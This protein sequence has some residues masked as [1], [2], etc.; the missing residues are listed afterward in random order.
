MRKFRIGAAAIFASALFSCAPM[1]TQTVDP[2]AFY[3]RDMKMD[4]NGF[5]GVG[6]LVV[7]QQYAWY[8]MKVWSKGKL[9]LF[10]F[11]TCHREQEA[12]DAGQGGLFGDRKMWEGEFY[13]VRGIEDKG[14]CL[15]RMGGY[16]K[17]VGQHSWGILDV[18]DQDHTLPATVKCNGAEY[19]SPGV[20]IC[21]SRKGL[22][23]EISFPVDVVLEQHESCKISEIGEG[24]VFRYQMPVKE[25]VFSFVEIAPKGK[26]RR[27]RLTTV[28]YTGILLHD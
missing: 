17:T 19:Q 20:T 23:Q 7:P 28:G 1:P 5:V 13:P 9:D 18:A 22:I 21:Q 26:Q 8:R 4:V 27:H 24:K 6:T 25:C 15:V 14:S 16:S 11:E 12:Q 2:A 10:T 3:K